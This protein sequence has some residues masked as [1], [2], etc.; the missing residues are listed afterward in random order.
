MSCS[1]HRYYKNK[2]IAL[3]WPWIQLSDLIVFVGLRVYVPLWRGFTVV[4]DRFVHDILVEIMADVSDNKLY[5]KLVGRLILGLKPR[6][7]AVFLLDVDEKTSLRR[8]QDIPNL[9]YLTR[10]RNSYQLITHHLGVPI[11]DAEQ[12]FIC[13]H[14]H[15]VE[16]INGLTSER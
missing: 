4:C 10:R 8:K 7:A 9:T 3:I 1:E 2:P 14:K 12:P 11:V 5:D 13:V 15:L 16:Q 6:S